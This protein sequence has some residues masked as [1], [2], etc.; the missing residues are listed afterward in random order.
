[1]TAR[2]GGYTRTGTTEAA[3][4]TA[5]YQT[6]WCGG[7]GGNNEFRREDAINSDVSCGGGGKVKHR[8][9]RRT[10]AGKL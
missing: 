3:A 10:D 5:E 4:A 9:G 7:G 8:G 6:H 2:E 1:M